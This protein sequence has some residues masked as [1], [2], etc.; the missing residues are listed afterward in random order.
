MS[1]AS[2]CSSGSCSRTKDP[3]SDSSRWSVTAAAVF[4]AALGSKILFWFEDPRLTS[5]HRHDTLYLLS[6][7]T[8]V[9][10]LIGGLLAVEAMKSLIG[11]R[12]A[13]GD[14]LAPSL[15]LGIAIGRVD[16]S[17]PAWRT[18][19]TASLLRCRGESILR[20]SVAAPH[21]A[22][23]IDLQ[24]MSFRF[25]VANAH[26][27]PQVGRCF[28]GFHGV[29]LFLAIGNRLPE[30]RDSLRR[31]FQY[32]V[33]LRR[34]AC[35]LRAGYSPLDSRQH[36]VASRSCRRDTIGSATRT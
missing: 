18:I 34:Y 12:H 20:R 7:K 14:L 28:S 10:A 27:S 5:V 4:G 22:L 21:P 13:T 32:S 30:A 2:P 25:L 26:A 16:A 15:A 3:I 29:L 11:E 23:R 9:G 36:S 33:G 35:L 1:L 8:L 24:P 19:L 6:G 31:T 17:S